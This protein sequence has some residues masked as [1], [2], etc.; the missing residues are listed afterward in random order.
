M[1]VQMKWGPIAMIAHKR[2]TLFQLGHFCIDLQLMMIHASKSILPTVNC[3]ICPPRFLAC[4]FD[5]TST[6]DSNANLD[7][8]SLGQANKLP[9]II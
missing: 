6:S 8:Y 1:H 4:T 7:L 3:F 9:T 2:G 5:R